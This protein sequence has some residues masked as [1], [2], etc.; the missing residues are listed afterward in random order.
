MTR[1]SALAWLRVTTEGGLIEVSPGAAVLFGFD[2][3]EDMRRHRDPLAAL[4]PRV[5]SWAQ[6]V[7]KD[8]SSISVEACR[9]PSGE[10]WLARMVAV[11]CAGEVV[12]S[13]E[14]PQPAAGRVAN[15]LLTGF[16]D[17]LPN[18]VLAKDRE[19][20]WVLLNDAYCRFMGYPREALLGRS[21]YDF[22]PK[23][24]ADVFWEKDNLVF[25]TGETNENE[26][27]FTDA[28]GRKHVIVTRKSLY[29]DTLGRPLLVAV[30]TD[31]TERKQMEQALRRS[32]DEL[33][34]AVAE[35]TAELTEANLR[36]HREL[37][38]LEQAERALRVSEELFRQ[39]ADSMPQIVWSGP[40]SGEIDYLNSKWTEY[41]GAPMS[42]EAIRDAIHREDVPGVDAKIRQALRTG[43][44]FEAEYRL[45][46]KDGVYRWHLGRALPMKDDEGGIVRWYGTFT[47]I[48]EQK[49]TQAA[50]VEEDRRK[51][52]F[53]AMLG[54]EL[55]NPLAPIRNAI[56]LLERRKEMCGERP[57]TILSRQVGHLAR[58]IDDLLDVSRISRGKVLLHTEPR[59]LRLVLRTSVEDHRPSAAGRGLDLQ[60]DVPQEP[61]PVRGD[62]T[63][64]S[65][66]VGNLLDN[67][68]KFT[69]PGGWIRVSAWRADDLVVAKV[70][71]SGIG[72]SPETL[73]G[74]FVPFSQAE[75]ALARTRGGLGLGLALVR[76]LVEMHGGKAFASSA[77]GGQGS[78]FVIELPVD[79]SAQVTAGAAG[80]AQGGWGALRILVI[81]DNE[82]AA[83]SLKML[84]ESEGHT[85]ELAG[86]GE[87]GIARAH[88]FRPQLILS[89]IGLPGKLSGYD[90]ART[91]RQDP[92][93]REVRLMA[94]SGYGRPDDKRR[95]LES[96]FERHL[97]KPVDLEALH[98]LL[99]SDPGHDDRPRPG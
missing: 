26:E 93:L 54:H 32:R 60:L 28:A 69:D 38:A 50:L 53:L 74:L 98:E 56:Y 57:L 94:V 31:V 73:Q 15:A 24:E 6:A 45:R 64:L 11:F 43:R 80:E 82:D 36:L 71:D 65:Q 51:N 95:A 67:A 4:F 68:E 97:T 88:S 79:L 78:E 49:R 27:A 7:A 44:G 40:P 86:N 92:L 77:G 72:M 12:A 89:D 25:E 66:V 99:S 87:E 34:H 84:L 85:V 2:S 9:R 63:R 41:T 96:G 33:D 5:R 14:E 1:G 61:L 81:E 76:G 55:R 47:D 20:R 42:A 37:G 16:V 58:L 10:D 29:T 39:L 21:D 75:Q 22:F 48:E 83:E 90:V 70:S 62:A 19:H 46:R 13:V 35:R 59:D 18:P 52:E 91:L 3:P 17:A 30:I 8:G 23:E